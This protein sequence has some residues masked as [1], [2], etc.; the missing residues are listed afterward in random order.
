MIKGP[1]AWTDA[2]LAKALLADMRRPFREVRRTHLSRLREQ[3]QGAAEAVEAAT[4]RRRKAHRWTEKRPGQL[5]AIRE[6]LQAG[7]AR[8][9]S[10]QA[11]RMLVLIAARPDVSISRKWTTA[12]APRVTIDVDQL[13]RHFH[14]WAASVV[15]NA[16]KLK[17]RAAAAEIERQDGLL[18][19][20]LDA[21][22]REPVRTYRPRR[23]LKAESA[24]VAH[25]EDL[26]G[27]HDVS[28]AP[29][30][31]LDDAPALQVLDG[32]RAL[33]KDAALPRQ[34]GDR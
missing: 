18:Y 7:D 4:N 17:A 31:A 19:A 34:N 16:A 11:R 1:R 25:D 26:L 8:R 13:R 12:K 15:H 24:D 30:I 20:T 29:W 33:R 22:E 14:H 23:R 32:G 27:L 3:A 5:W 2:E 10:S 6:E 28:E 21:D 9:L